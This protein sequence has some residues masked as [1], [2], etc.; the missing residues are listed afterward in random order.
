MKIYL[1][2]CS[3]YEV[4]TS[5]DYS[6]IDGI[7]L[8][9]ERSDEKCVAADND[10]KSIVSSIKGPVF[11]S[12]MGSDV[13]ELLA[14]A[15]R[16]VHLSPNVVVKVKATLEGFKVC[17]LLSGKNIPVSMSGLKSI[18]KAIM[19]AKSGADFISFDMNMVQQKHNDDFGFLTDTI[20]IFHKHN[21]CADVLA[22]ISCNSTNLDI[23]SRTGIH[24]LEI[25]FTNLMSFMGNSS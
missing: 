14:D 8:L 17:K 7:S 12:A 16:L 23:I 21:L 10:I 18:T 5:V 13:E 15:L 2:T 20:R 11:I 6:L 25:S 19:A 24:G 9:S 3:L 4:K 22:D 1:K